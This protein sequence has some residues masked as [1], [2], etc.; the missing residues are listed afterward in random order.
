MPVHDESAAPFIELIRRADQ[1][2]RG[3]VIRFG[4]DG[5]VLSASD[6][7]LDLI[8]Y[9]RADFEKGTIDWDAMTP[10]EYWSLDDRCLAQLVQGEIA[11]SYVKELVRKD[12][13]RVAIRLFSAR[14]SASNTEI[15]AVAIELLE[16][17]NPF[18]RYA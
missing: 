14:R 16:P 5:T 17:A 9:S 11:D 3:A 2:P 13:S 7:F 8:R 15:V 1:D 12:G 6:A 10:P 4:R 18:S